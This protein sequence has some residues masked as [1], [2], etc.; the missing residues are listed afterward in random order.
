[1]NHGRFKLLPCCLLLAIFAF[2][3]TATAQGLMLK[4]PA[5]G[6]WSRFRVTHQGDVSF[7]RD[8]S[9]LPDTWKDLLATIPDF[10]HSEA[11]LVISSVGSEEIEGEQ[12]RWIELFWKSTQEPKKEGEDVGTLLRLLVAEKVL[13][14]GGDPLD[15][16]RVVIVKGGF[17]DKEAGAIKNESR[18][19]WE[20]Q[21]F[22]Q[23]FP[24]YTLSG[25]DWAH[26]RGQEK[27]DHQS[28][29]HEKAHRFRFNY[30][31]KGHG[32]EHGSVIHHANYTVI[33]DP[34]TPFG[35]RQIWETDGVTI[36]DSGPYDPTDKFCDGPG[37][38][39]RGN[40]QIVLIESGTKAV[41][42][43]KAIA[44]H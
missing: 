28:L 18:R 44:E 26:V 36:E 40:S 43:W 11:E 33:A 29:P 9:E 16:A 2:C 1:M 38:V 41:S 21:R 37:I 10:A 22:R 30:Q 17:S 32:G 20:L 13:S 23:F 15:N 6:A 14:V 3:S 24:K 7:L 35:V 4:L 39:M 27:S 31:G 5:D 12:F 19:K 34:T 8:L 25:K 42:R